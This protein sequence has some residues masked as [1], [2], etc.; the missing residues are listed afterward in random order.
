MKEIMARDWAV[1][2]TVAVAGTPDRAC[3][4]GEDNLGSTPLFGDCLC[5]GGISERHDTLDWDRQLA[6]ACRLCIAQDRCG[7]DWRD[8]DIDL[9]SRMQRSVSRVLRWETTKRATFLD[10]GK[11]LAGELPTDG[12]GGAV[13]RTEFINL[14]IIIDGDGLAHSGKVSSRVQSLATN[15]SNDAG[16]D[17]RCCEDR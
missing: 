13:E 14:C 15:A 2:K 5:F 9:N 4:G 7:V 3:S 17:L 11:E 10:P 6:V 16:P 1:M 8:N 12:V